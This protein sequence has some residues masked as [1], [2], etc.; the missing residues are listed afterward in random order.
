M[1][2]EVKIPRR[3]FIVP[4][5]NR[6]QHKFFFSKYMSFIL[7]NDEDYEI[8]F[9]HQC[10]ARTFN[11][12]AVKDIGFIAI[13]NKYP[14]HYKDITFIFNDVDTI[15]FTKNECNSSLLYLNDH[16]LYLWQ[17]TEDFLQAEDFL[18]GGNIQISKA[19]WTEKMKNVILKVVI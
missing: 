6:I 17:K 8:Y 10:D 2:T 4:Y 5:R 11:R 14:Q 19:N 13:R 18:K 3:V 9:T 1:T 16:V 15:P 7:E 12:G